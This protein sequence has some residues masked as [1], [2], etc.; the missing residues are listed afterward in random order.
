M[1]KPFSYIMSGGRQS[2]FL[3]NR[4]R[5]RLGTDDPDTQKLAL[6]LL[7]NPYLEPSG[8]YRLSLDTI[9]E[10]TGFSSLKLV[11]LLKTLSLLGFCSYDKESEYIQ[12]PLVT[13]IYAKLCS[14]SSQ[15]ESYGAV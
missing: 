5:R 15:G 3:R 12:V 8:C 10:Y 2:N 1:L 6:Y 14:T 11:S 9:K 4:I 13:A 7:A